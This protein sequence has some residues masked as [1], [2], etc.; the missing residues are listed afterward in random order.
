[1]AAVAVAVLKQTMQQLVVLA[2]EVALMAVA[3]QMALLGLLVKVML[4]A[5]M[6]VLQLH[7]IL[8]AAAV[9]QVD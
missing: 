1:L 3:L 6:A 8:L 5:A 2:V 4:V 7:L 9:A